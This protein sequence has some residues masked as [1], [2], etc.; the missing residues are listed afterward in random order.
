MKEIEML[1]V[2][3]VIAAQKPTV[4]ICPFA[5]SCRNWL[6][7]LFLLFLVASAP[8]PAS[9]QG[10]FATS[11][12]FAVSLGATHHFT[13]KSI[14]VVY[15]PLSGGAVSG[16]LTLSGTPANNS[17]T[18][19]TDVHLS[20][21]PTSGGTPTVTDIVPFGT[22]VLVHGQLYH[23]ASV[24][25][26]PSGNSFNLYGGI[27]STSAQASSAQ[28]RSAQTRNNFSSGRAAAAKRKQ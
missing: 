11:N 18:F 22:V 24:G 9:A 13:L 2:P 1:S 6:A 12:P 23:L 16:F 27:I 15:K 21:S 14:P 28:T 20:F 19:F 5:L 7:G 10:T 26:S 3:R 17:L 8:V 25:T 4:P